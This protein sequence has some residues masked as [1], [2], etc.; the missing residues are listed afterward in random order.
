MRSLQDHFLIAMPAMGD[1]N[2]HETVT[3]VCTHDAEGALGIVINRP[4][5]MPLGKVF[6]ELSLEVLDHKQSVRPV[7]SG[8]PMAR[9]RGFVLHH[10]A[11]DYE[12]TLETGSDIRVTLSPDIL[13]AIARGEGP[14]PVLVALGYA[15]WGAGQL[16][17]ELGANTWLSVQA[18]RSILF[19][20]PFDQRW[21]AAVGLLGVDIHQITTYAGHA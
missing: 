5:E 11:N 14:E 15:G 17:A 21:A 3:Y 4:T 10:S 1:P 16:E 7:L 18:D 9:D 6:A 2:F 19:E 12:S 20:T 8:G 13:S